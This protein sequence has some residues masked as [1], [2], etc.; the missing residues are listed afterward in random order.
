MSNTLKTSVGTLFH[1]PHV[2]ESKKKI[3]CNGFIKKDLKLRVRN[4]KKCFPPLKQCLGD[5]LMQIFEFMSNTLKTSM[6]T[7]FHSPHVKESK[8]KYM[9]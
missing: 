6:R 4:K 5:H 3:S 7:L 2:K 8:N 9:M 1:S